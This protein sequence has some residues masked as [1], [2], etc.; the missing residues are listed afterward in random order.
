MS[1]H[2][3]PG[4]SSSTWQRSIG[5]KEVKE[6][7]TKGKGGESG[8]RSAFH[9]GCSETWSQVKCRKYILG[10]YA[11]DMARGVTYV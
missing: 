8:I 11:V 4:Q 2:T 7:K 3:T 5:D 6:R 9:L 10:R 1:G